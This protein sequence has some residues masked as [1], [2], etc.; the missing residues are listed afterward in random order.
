MGKTFKDSP[1]D[2]GRE[3]PTERDN[4]DWKA[5][6][7]AARTRKKIR[8]GEFVGMRSERARGES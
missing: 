4:G 7:K 6:R 1:T 5:E 8:R 3:E 2:R